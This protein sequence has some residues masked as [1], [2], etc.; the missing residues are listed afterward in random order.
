MDSTIWRGKVKP[1]KTSGGS[2]RRRE[3]PFSSPS[4]LKGRVGAACRGRDGRR[5]GA[6]G[7]QV[8]IPR[9]SY[10]SIS[11][12]N[13]ELPGWGAGVTQ[14]HLPGSVPLTFWVNVG[15]W[16]WKRTPAP[17]PFFALRDWTAAASSIPERWPWADQTGPPRVQVGESERECMWASPADR[18]RGVTELAHRA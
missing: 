8:H 15:V 9:F 14:G 16:V 3:H 11:C 6:A 2:F 13:W 5:A 4:V 12:P 7:F 10:V 17:S 18:S 1:N